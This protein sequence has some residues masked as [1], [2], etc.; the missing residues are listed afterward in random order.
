MDLTTQL[1]SLYAPGVAATIEVPETT[2]PAMVEEVAGRYPQRAAI[3]FFSRQTTYAELV[4]QIRKAAGALAAAGVRPGDRVALVMPNCPQHAVAVLGA[5]ALGAVVVE[6]NPLAPAAE[7]RGEYEAHGARTTIAWTK[8]L[9][10]LSFL[11]PGHTVFAMDLVRALPRASQF[12]VRLPLRIH[13]CFHF[14]NSA[15]GI[16]IGD[17]AAA[18]VFELGFGGRGEGLVNGGRHSLAE[19]RLKSFQMACFT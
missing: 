3:D 10:K 6:H 7:L 14:I 4:I 12:L 8:S 15:H 19:G 9:E 13:Q 5:M 18:F 17:E 2:I 11:D 1:R 16:G